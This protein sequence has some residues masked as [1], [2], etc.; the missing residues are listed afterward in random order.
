VEP[1]YGALWTAQRSI[2]GFFSC[3]TDLRRRLN[4]KSSSNLQTIDPEVQVRGAPSQKI[5]E[6]CLHKIAYTPLIFHLL[7][8]AQRPHVRPDFVNML[9]TFSLGSLFSDRMP[10]FRNVLAAQPD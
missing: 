9:Q 3:G 6:A 1:E 8:Q 4:S 2:S 7:P 10:S 5:R